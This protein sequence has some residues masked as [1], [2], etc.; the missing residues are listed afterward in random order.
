MPFTVLNGHKFH[1]QQAGS[2]PDL[3]LIHG[4]TGDLSGVHTN[5]ETLH[6]L[7]PGDRIATGA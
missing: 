7:I 2:G 1:Y 3:V 6:G 5:V 4:L